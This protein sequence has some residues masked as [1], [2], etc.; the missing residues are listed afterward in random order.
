[1]VYATEASFL[2]G[3]TAVNKRSIIISCGAMILGTIIW[4][5]YLVIGWHYF[6]MPYPHVI[7][8]IFR[9]DGEVAQ[10]AI[11]GEIWLEFVAAAAIVLI[12]AR[13]LWRRISN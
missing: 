8:P 9:L 1:M 4:R 2:K 6:D 10:D 3:R 5:A 12:G 13:V 11:Y 7:A